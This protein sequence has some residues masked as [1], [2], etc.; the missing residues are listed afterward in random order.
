[1][2]LFDL[3]KLDKYAD[4]AETSTAAASLASYATSN[5][6]G[7]AV[8][9]GASL[10]GGVIDIYQLTRELYKGNNKEAVRNGLELLGSLLG[11]KAVSLGR[12]LYKTGSTIDKTIKAYNT[13]SVLSDISSL[14]KSEENAEYN[15]HHIMLDKNMLPISYNMNNEY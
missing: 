9:Y 12:K 3:N 1:M 6:I 10:L 14:A 2:A 8:G 15:I 5:P 11:L 7:A 13:L 4:Y